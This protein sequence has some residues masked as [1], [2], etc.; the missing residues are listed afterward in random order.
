MEELGKDL[1]KT[2]QVG[3]K[4]T[5]KGRFPLYGTHKRAGEKKLRPVEK[6]GIIN[7]YWA[8]VSISRPE[9]FDQKGKRG[10]SHVI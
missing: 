9:T 6:S 5:Q 7:T 2:Q 1:R 8:R 3:E 10:E 4:T